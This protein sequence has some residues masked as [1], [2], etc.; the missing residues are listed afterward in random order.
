MNGFNSAGPRS[1]SS[2]KDKIPARRAGNAHKACRPT[3]KKQFKLLFL[4][5]IPNSLDNFDRL[6]SALWYLD[7]EPECLEKRPAELLL[8]AV[9][10]VDVDLF[11]FEYAAPNLFSL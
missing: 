7:M 2:Q 6:A 5:W 11:L 1:F 3:F 4:F 8:M 9:P 10:K